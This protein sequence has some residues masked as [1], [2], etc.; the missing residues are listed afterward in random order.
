[1][2]SKIL[3]YFFWGVAIPVTVVWMCVAGGIHIGKDYM[4]HLYP[5]Q[6]CIC[7]Y[8]YIHLYIY[9]CMLP[10]CGG[11]T[12]SMAGWIPVLCQ[13]YL[14]ESRRN[15]W[16]YIHPLW[17]PNPSRWTIPSIYIYIY[18]SPVYLPI[19]LQTS[20][21]I[22]LHWFVISIGLL[23]TIEMRPPKIHDL[24]CCKQ[25]IFITTTMNHWNSCSYRCYNHQE[26]IPVEIALYWLT[27]NL[28]AIRMPV[29]VIKVYHS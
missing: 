27:V 11:L 8:M 4:C 17:Y 13:F 14:I 15:G 21:F 19:M 12:L 10:M 24:N 3:D 5:I 22:V 29:V 25:A 16:L 28:T 6:V 1:M 20:I 26:F 18:I 2:V 7:M 23:R 9:M